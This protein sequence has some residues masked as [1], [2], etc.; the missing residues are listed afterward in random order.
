MKVMGRLTTA[1]TRL[2]LS[3]V[4]AF[5]G[6]FGTAGLAVALGSAH[7]AD[8]AASADCKATA[9]SGVA[10]RLTEPTQ[11]V[12]ADVGETIKVV[13]H[14]RGSWVSVPKALTHPQAVCR[15]S[16]HRVSRGKVVAWFRAL[17]ARKVEFGSYAAGFE[18]AP[19]IGYA[20]ISGRAPVRTH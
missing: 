20:R 14:L 11:T 3:G 2:V 15:I 13:I 7:I 8:S 16:W 19:W 18:G 5:A 12:R 4:M 6:A 17:R 9:G 10:L 1:R